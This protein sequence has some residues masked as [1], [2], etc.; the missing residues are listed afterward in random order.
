ME[1]KE[2]CICT[3]LECVT[4]T[5]CS[6]IQRQC[7]AYDHNAKPHCVDSK[8]CCYIRGSGLDV[9]SMYYSKRDFY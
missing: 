3:L 8:C 7:T 6:H 2:Q 4:A 1:N 5:D 9:V